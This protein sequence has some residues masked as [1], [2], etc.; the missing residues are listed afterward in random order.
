VENLFMPNF[1]NCD[2]TAQ[3]HLG[4]FFVVIDAP[5]KGFIL[6][7][8]KEKRTK[9][10]KQNQNSQ[11]SMTSLKSLKFLSRTDKAINI[12]LVKIPRIY[13]LQKFVFESR[14]IISRYILNRDVDFRV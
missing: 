10:E 14:A 13:N 1:E 3:A 8:F 6:S 11:M 12:F 7:T 2:Y 9:N 4:L 5:R